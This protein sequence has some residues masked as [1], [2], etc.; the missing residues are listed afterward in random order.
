MK[1]IYINTIEADK[2]DLNAL[3]T[4]IEKKKDRIKRILFFQNSIRIYTI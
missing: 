3:R 4:A 1:K 2:N